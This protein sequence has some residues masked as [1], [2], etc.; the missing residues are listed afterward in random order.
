MPF[1]IGVRDPSR[2]S[3]DPPGPQRGRYK[4]LQLRD[5]PFASHAHRTPRCRPT[6]TLAGGRPVHVP[7][8]R[9]PA[10]TAGNGRSRGRSSM[11]DLHAPRA[12][13]RG[14]ARP[15]VKPMAQDVQPLPTRHGVF[16]RRT[17]GG[18]PSGA[19]PPAEGLGADPIS[20]R[21]P[22]R[23]P[24]GQTSSDTTLRSLCPHS[25]VFRPMC[26]SPSG[27]FTSCPFL[28]SGFCEA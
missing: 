15:S 17:T 22:S 21:A 26:A 9:E 4:G 7:A 16:R 11:L 6:R 23:G 28:G 3:R 18:T 5:L 8:P 19:P 10:S 2:K 14:G 24:Q 1:N 12:S 27:T 13:K 25:L 20:H